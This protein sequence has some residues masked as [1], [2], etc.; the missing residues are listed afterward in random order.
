MATSDPAAYRK[1]TAFFL[2]MIFGILAFIVSPVTSWLMSILF[3]GAD[4]KSTEFWA[5]RLPTEIDRRFTSPAN[6]KPSEAEQQ[7]NLR[8]QRGHRS[9]EANVPDEPPR[10]SI[11]RGDVD[12]YPL[13]ARICELLRIELTEAGMR[14]ASTM[15]QNVAAGFLLVFSFSFCHPRLP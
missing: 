9:T 6:V 8:P 12:L 2:A 14:K 10:F 3:T 1:Q 13:F 11:Q 7:Q 15:I 4:P 5:I